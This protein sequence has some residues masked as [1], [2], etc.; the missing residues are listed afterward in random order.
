MIKYMKY[1]IQTL[2]VLIV[3]LVVYAG[4]S[5]GIPKAQPILKATAD[6]RTVVEGQKEKLHYVAIGDSLTEGIG[7][8]TSR[9]GFVP[10]LANDLQERYKLTTIEIDNFGVAGER[11]DQI[12]KRIKKEQIQKNLKSA[13]FVTLTVGGNDLMKV[14]QDNFF[15]LSIKSFNRPREKYQKRVAAIIDEVREDNPEVPIY[16]LGIYNP[17]F[18]NFPEITD[19]QTVVDDWNEATQ[20]TV[21][22][23]DKVHFI[24]INELL[25][26]GIGE[27]AGVTSE[28]TNSEESAVEA[29]TH[30]SSDIKT[31][32]NNV[33]SDGDKFHPNNTGYQ[34]MANAVRDEMLKT[35]KEWLEE[36][37]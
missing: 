37:E 19:M 17:F 31:V 34:L 4:L 23:Y 32:D 30:N 15:G 29:K 8:Q 5:S 16:V 12:L 18:L 11:S 9:G 10:L 26:Q 22:S 24:P 27:Q 2:L 35:R 7:D 1:V 36:N 13:D 3:A 20:K 25:Y 21:D 28:L 14:I 6:T 33:L